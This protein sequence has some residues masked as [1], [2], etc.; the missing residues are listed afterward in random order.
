MVNMFFY[1]PEEVKKQQWEE[2]QAKAAATGEGNAPPVAEWDIPSVPVG[3]GINLALATQD[4]AINCAAEPPGGNDWV[5][6]PAA[7]TGWDAA[8]AALD[9]CCFQCTWWSLNSTQIGTETPS[10]MWDEFLPQNSFNSY[11]TYCP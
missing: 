3:G 6:E 2:V 4:G 8:P 7:A 9:Y 5:V 10:N 11:E 1:H